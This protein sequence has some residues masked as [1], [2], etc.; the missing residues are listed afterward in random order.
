MELGDPQHAF[1]WDVDVESGPI[2]VGYRMRYISKQVLNTYEDLFTLQG[3]PPENADFAE[4]QFYPSTF[5]HDVRFAIEVSD[6]FE[7]SGG[8]QNLLNTLPPFG[9]SGAGGG[10]GIYDNRGRFFYAGFKAKF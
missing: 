9:L 10:S 4:L 6:K 3:R 7:F 2:S 5:Y 8:V 1:N